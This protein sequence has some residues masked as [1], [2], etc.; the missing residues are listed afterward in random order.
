[1]LSLKTDVAS[2]AFYGLLLLPLLYVLR[3][4]TTSSPSQPSATE[5]SNE[6]T[7]SK[8]EEKPKTIMSAANTS[9]QPPK[10]DE[11]TPERLKDYDGS[12]PG[13]PIY[14]AIKGTIFDVTA[15]VEMY[16]P[17][18]SYNIFAG[19][20]GSRGLG[21]SSLKPE[22]A[23]PDYSTLD[24]NDM[25][26]LDDWHSFFSKRYNIVGRVV[27]PNLSEAVRNMNNL[28]LKS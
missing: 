25:K 23:V 13:K 9:L 6:L 18:K 7:G 28:Q 19:K 11:F 22:D 8:E 27:D 1:M 3:K 20:D 14:V 17:G 16:G 2:L 26:V 21:M 15:K 4:Y 12:Q 10:D 24:E 5:N